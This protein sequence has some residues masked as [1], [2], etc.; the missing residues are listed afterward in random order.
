[1]IREQWEVLEHN[2]NYEVSNLGKVRN[3]STG[4]IL[5]NRP[6]SKGYHRISINVGGKYKDLKIHRLVATYFIENDNPL[7]KIEVNHKDGNKGNNE[8][9]NLEWVTPSEN[10]LHAFETGLHSHIGEKNTNLKLTDEE[11]LKIWDSNLT[12]RQ[13]EKIYGVSYGYARRLLKRQTRTYL[14]N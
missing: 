5:S 13:I 9:T 1:M 6:D 10:A 2:P 3:I 7:D 8:Y 4:R 14:L 11:V 12:A